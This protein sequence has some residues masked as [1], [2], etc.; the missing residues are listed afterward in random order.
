VYGYVNPGN[1]V[2]Y[3]YVIVN[4]GNQS[5]QLS[6]FVLSL[7]AVFSFVGGPPSA[8]L[9]P[10]EGLVIRIN[11]TPLSTSPVNAFLTYSTSILTSPSVTVPVYLNDAVIN[12]VSS[13]TDTALRIYPNPTEGIILMTGG[14]GFGDIYIAD[15]SGRVLVQY[16][17]MPLESVKLDLSFLSTGAYYLQMKSAEGVSVRTLLKR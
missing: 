11:A 7:P 16:K 17:D 2:T 6:N 9:Q 13:V 4:T 8:N 3:S 12:T 1:T 15:F 10:G 5:V 14:H